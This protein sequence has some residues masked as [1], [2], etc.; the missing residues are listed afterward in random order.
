[1]TAAMLVVSI[2]LTAQPSVQQDKQK[3]PSAQEQEE[4]ALAKRVYEMQ[5]SG[6]DSDFY[7]AHGLSGAA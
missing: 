3:Q 6:S 4:Q 2:T 7:G 1:M 5:M